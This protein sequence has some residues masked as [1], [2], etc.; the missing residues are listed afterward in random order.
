MCTLVGSQQS[1]TQGDPSKQRHFK[2]GLCSCLL[3]HHP[4]VG[5]NCIPGLSADIHLI[6]IDVAAGHSLELCNL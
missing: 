3:H 6:H 4:F 1:H 5:R 2:S